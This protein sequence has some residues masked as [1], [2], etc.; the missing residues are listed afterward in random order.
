MFVTPSK[1]AKTQEWWPSVKHLDG[2]KMRVVREFESRYGARIIVFKD[3]TGR[4]RQWNKFNLDFCRQII[5]E[6]K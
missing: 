4:V 1:G 6:N 3:S 5:L 2:K